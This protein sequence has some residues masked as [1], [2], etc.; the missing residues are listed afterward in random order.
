MILERA[1]ET[2]KPE[3]DLYN[4]AEILMNIVVATDAMKMC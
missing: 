4:N 1:N 3:L 2:F